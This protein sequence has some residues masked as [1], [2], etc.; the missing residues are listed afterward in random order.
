MEFIIPFVIFV[1]VAVA[2]S[3]AIAYAIKESK[4]LG[5][6]YGRLAAKFGG[7]AQPA[8]MFGRPSARFVYNGAHVLVDIYSTGGK[9]PTHY[10]QVH[11][12]WP[13]P[14]FRCEV[15]PASFFTR[16][17]NFLG[18]SDIEIGSAQFDA[19]Y[20]ISGSNAEAIR[21]LLSPGVQAAIDAI[22]SHLGNGHVYVLFSGGTLLVK[23]LKLISDYDSLAHLVVLSL[24]LFDQALLTRES[25]IEFVAGPPPAQGPPR[26]QVCGEAISTDL[27]QCRSCHTPHHRDCWKYYGACSTYGCRE[28]RFVAPRASAAG[29]L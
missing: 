23:K 3:I 4:T 13:D 1:L 8:T 11:V 16:I 17:G 22:R 14:A 12:S 2:V 28:T 24:E 20:Q 9:H 29:T 25:G 26:C 5:E 15:Y 7:T 21:Q 18:M 6:T 27:V 10:T 19:A